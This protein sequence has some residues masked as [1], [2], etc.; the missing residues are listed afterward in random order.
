MTSLLWRIQCLVTLHFQHI[1]SEVVDPMQAELDSRTEPSDNLLI[2]KLVDHFVWLA[3]TKPIPEVSH[4][5][6][7]E[8]QDFQIH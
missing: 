7:S 3:Q 2:E 6:A 4:R 1:N 8:I 5:Q